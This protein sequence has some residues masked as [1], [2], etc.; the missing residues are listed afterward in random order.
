MLTYRTELTG[1]QFVVFD[2]LDELVGKYDTEDAANKSITEFMKEDAM[3]E[4]A[5]LLIESA[6]KAHMEQFNVSREMAGYWIRCGAEVVASIHA[7]P[8]Q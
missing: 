6:I 8:G 1:T 5:K 2:S 4:T 7:D 3:Y